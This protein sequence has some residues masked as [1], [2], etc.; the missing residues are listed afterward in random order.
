MAQLTARDVR[1]ERTPVVELLGAPPRL[2][3]V[4][5][6]DGRTMPLRAILTAPKLR[7]ASPLAGQ[8][9]CAL[10]E[11]PLGPPIRVDGWKQTTVQGVYAAGDAVSWMHN[12]TVA[13]ASGVT[14]GIGAHQSLAGATVRPA[15]ADARRA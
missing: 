15:T 11:E 13:S 3:A 4:S 12:A 8:L 2:E 9:C 10:D 5:L 6:G 7:M 14:A 1:I